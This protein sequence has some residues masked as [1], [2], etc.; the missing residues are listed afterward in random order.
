MVVWR[1]KVAYVHTYSKLHIN[2]AFVEIYLQH[3]CQ[4]TL[5]SETLISS[6]ATTQRLIKILCPKTFSS[7]RAENSSSA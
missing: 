2:L 3:E 7:S 1:E 4:L 5:Q 6:C